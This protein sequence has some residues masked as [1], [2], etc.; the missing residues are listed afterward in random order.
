MLH[1][2]PFDTVMAVQSAA[3]CNSPRVLDYARELSSEVKEC[4]SVP[5]SGK[6]CLIQWDN[7]GGAAAVNLVVLKFLW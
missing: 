5:A 6:I 3:T 1:L 7:L 4:N 2:N